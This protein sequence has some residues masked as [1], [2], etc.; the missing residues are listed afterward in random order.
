MSSFPDKV[1]ILADDSIKKLFLDESE[2]QLAKISSLLVSLEGDFENPSPLAEL[3]RACHSFKGAARLVGLGHLVALAHKLEDCFVCAQNHKITLNSESLNI[4]LSASDY[5]NALRA[6][7]FEYESIE[8][9]DNLIHNIDSILTQKPIQKS[10]SAIKESK[11][12]LFSETIQTDDDDSVK[13]SNEYLNKLLELT[14]ES[15]IENKSLPTNKN[16]LIKI[17]SR[18]L[19]TLFALDNAIFALEAIP[20]AKNLAIKLRHTQNTVK[21]TLTTISEQIKFMARFT[22]KNSEISNKLYEQIFSGTMR[23]LKDISIAFP[24]LVRDLSLALNKKIQLKISGENCI[25]DRKLLK[26]LDA[27]I[28]H[29]LRNACDHG[30][31]LTEERKSLKK[32]E[33]ATINLEASHSKTSF[34]L[35]ISD[36]G[37]GL[38]IDKIKER[39]VKLKMSKK[40][41]LD[42][43]SDEEIFSFLFLPKFSLSDKVN[44]VSGRGVGL[45]VVQTTMQSMCGSINVSSELNKGTSFTLTLPLSRATLKALIILISNQYY[46]FAMDN[47]HAA[48]TLKNA[49]EISYQGKDLKI[50][51]AAQSL[52]LD[53]YTKDSDLRNF[54]IIE[55]NKEFLAIEIQKFLGESELI[56][57][58]ANKL[59]SKIPCILATSIHND[60]KPIIVL[61]TNLV[62]DYSQKSKIKTV[63]N[64]ILVVDD[65]PTVRE[66]IVNIL[67]AGG[68][69]TDTAS[70]G[71]DA[72]G[73]VRVSDYN[74]IISDI[75]MPK[76]NGLS[77]LKKIKDA[78]I[79]TPFILVSYK[80][81]PA[82][83]E[84]GLKAGANYYISKAEIE[85]KTLLEK[86]NSLIK[87]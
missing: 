74:L 50:I 9:C 8:T 30:I 7:R 48:I 65:S 47:I 11:I 56:L 17:K 35:K 52:E 21:D 51:D 38:N 87:Q 25:L 5:I 13:V 3:M 12:N 39:I 76:L 29:I 44:E 80:D 59:L 61:D 22:R 31:E 14:T 58:P 18:T 57:H 75:D 1:I 66:R 71:E 34:V 23:P 79:P 4:L 26:K 41:M 67:T 43:M 28:R 86:I 73:A 32:D 77:L 19:K 45:D 46:A 55:K 40:S 15:I 72:W 53:S 16:A 49:S 6:I 54:I 10:A 70:D 64:R 2:I 42:N 63:R 78:N 81:S 20:E 36:D 68:Y 83:I 62:A 60:G 27:P 82:D 24:R 33:T 69:D 84:I 37:R 85:S